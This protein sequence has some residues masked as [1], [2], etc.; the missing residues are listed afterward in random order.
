MFERKRKRAY[1]KKKKNL[2]INRD[3]IFE[4]LIYIYSF[5]FFCKTI[6]IIFLSILLKLVI[7]WKKKK[8]LLKIKNS[9]NIITNQIHKN[10]NESS[11]YFACFC[12]KARKE[13]KYVRELISY[14]SK[15]GVE[16]FIFGDNNYIGTEKLT[17][18]IQDYVDSGQVDIYEIFGSNISQNEFCQYIY[19]K[20]KNKCKWFLFFDLDEYLEVYFENK[21]PLM[22][23][24]FLTNKNFDKCESLLFNWVIYTDND[25]LYYDNR[26]LLERFTSFSYNN[27]ANVY[28]KSIV[29]GGLNKTIFYPKKSN[30]VPDSN[31][32]ICDSI[33]RIRTRYNPFTIQPPVF[34]YGI[35]K[36]FAT[37]TTEEFIEKTKRGYNG[38][39]PLKPE[40]R[41]IVFFS[42]NKF[43]EEKL[44]LFEKGFNKSFDTI[45]YRFRKNSN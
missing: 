22:L 28:V 2:L 35:L 6:F 45:K 26:P 40:D 25:L 34:D 29:R 19:E 14:Y 24:D 15:I 42:H 7:L 21:K 39:I 30:H 16:K 20:Y 31:V 9:E 8:K 33:G 43:T 17:D 12:A 32:I 38:N 37:K 36:H 44:K 1:K 23:Q 41:I 13:N 5:N 4:N 10:I 11:E 3:F 27:R 18:V